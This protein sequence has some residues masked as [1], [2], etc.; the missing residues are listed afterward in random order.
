MMKKI[1]LAISLS[2]IL[3][4]GSA[5]AITVY[6]SDNFTYKLGGDLQVQYRQNDGANQDLFL[7]YDDAELKN[8]V[9]YQANENLSFFGQLDF[10][11]KS[12]GIQ[13]IYLG[14]SYGDFNFLV[15]ETDF[16]TAG[17]GV[18]RAIEGSSIED[19]FP[20]DDGDDQFQIEYKSEGLTALLSHDL[21]ADD[22][23]DES[24]DIA[25]Y[26][27]FDNFEL[28]LGYQVFKDN[29]AAETV[30][31]FGV[32]AE[33]E[34]DKFSIGAA[35]SRNDSNVDLSVIH[36]SSAYQVNE[37]GKLAAGY[38][39]AEQTTGDVDSWYINYTSKMP[40]VKN[41]TVFGE[42]SNT[43][44]DNSDPGFLVGARLKF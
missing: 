33:V 13:E 28:G 20:E 42:I 14:V 15:G 5:N 1:V 32:S 17:F 7:D 30:K 41:V 25:I 21:S 9:R 2:S 35:L 27:E 36:L 23:D 31:T 11:F 18:E 22:T 29:A 4:I 12:V 10:D 26:K 3:G 8:N 40:D 37:L 39:I 6:E 38:E 16:A 34:L 44:A 43:D 19:A 24:T